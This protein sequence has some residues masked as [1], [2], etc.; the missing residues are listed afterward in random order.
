MYEFFEDEE[1]AW[2]ITEYC[3]GGELFDKITEKDQL[4]EQ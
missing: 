3:N 2:L 4:E 1:S